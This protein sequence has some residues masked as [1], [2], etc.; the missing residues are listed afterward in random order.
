V[1]FLQ[2]KNLKIFCLAYDIICIQKDKICLIPNELMKGIAASTELNRK[3]ST[4]EKVLYFARAEF[5]L[6]KKQTLTHN[7]QET[8]MKILYEICEIVCIDE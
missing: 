2:Y 7:K 5:Y 4:L 1:E 3:N 6:S 8:T